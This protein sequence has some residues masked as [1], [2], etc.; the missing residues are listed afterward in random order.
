MPAPTRSSARKSSSSASLADLLLASMCL[1]LS[2]LPSDGMCGGISP[3]PLAAA[4]ASSELRLGVPK[5]PR[6]PRDCLRALPS[7]VEGVPCPSVVDA[8]SVAR[9]FRRR[10]LVP[11]ADTRVA[12]LLRRS[13]G[14]TRGIWVYRSQSLPP[15]SRS[16]PDS[17]E[18]DADENDEGEAAAPGL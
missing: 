10:A 17:D 11:A 16:V 8:A 12:E 9:L 4:P 1:L 3:L 7:A 15:L 18:T 5:L 2:R 13:R 14:E 6:P